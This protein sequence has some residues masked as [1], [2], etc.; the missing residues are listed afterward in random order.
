MTTDFISTVRPPVVDGY[1]TP[2]T[3]PTFPTAAI[4]SS[5]SN[6]LSSKVSNI[7]SASYADVEIRDALN[8]L[9][10]QGI[11]NNAETRRRLRM[12]VQKEVIESNGDIIREFG[13]IAHVRTFF[14]NRSLS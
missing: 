10:E 9:D 6:A 1:N 5:R 8:L 14:L 12:D 11:E 7:L 3:S 4:S 13:H 2:P